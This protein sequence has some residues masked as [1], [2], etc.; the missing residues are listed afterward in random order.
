MT[1]REQLSDPRQ[2]GRMFEDICK[3][4]V[5]YTIYQPTEETLSDQFWKNFCLECDELLSRYQCRLF[6]DLMAAVMDEC[7][8]RKREQG[9]ANGL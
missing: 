6:D 4:L 2:W 5:K 3:F 7:T 9:K 8:R 1:E